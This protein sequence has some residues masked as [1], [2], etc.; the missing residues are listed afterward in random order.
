MKIAI[1]GGKG[2][3][4]GELVKSLKNNR[5][6]VEIIDKNET[7]DYREVLVEQDYTW[8]KNY[9]FIFH[10]GAN[11]ST[12]AKLFEKS[13]EPTLFETNFLFSCQVILAALKYNI[14][15]IFASSGAIYGSD[16]R[17]GYGLPLTDYGRSKLWVERFI[18][19]CPESIKNV[20]SLRF[21]NVYGAYEENK[22][23][24]ASI[25]YKVLKNGKNKIELFKGS[26][27]I[28]R[29]FIHVDDVVNCMIFFLNYYK[30]HKKLPSKKFYDV[31]TGKAVSFLDIAT[32]L[33]K[34][35][36]L[37]IKYINNPYSKEKYQFFTQ[38]NTEDLKKL[39]LSEEKSWKPVNFKAGIK[40]THKLI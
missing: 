10:L 34:Y 36:N 21:H 28:K 1:T 31:G 12:R 39:Y 37:P 32:E 30:K 4:G 20:I 33:Q 22:R 5:H 23:N 7:L 16:R 40:K 29:D 27:N 24:M 18:K 13:K 26:E 3:I 2:F 35:T 8:V 25:V 14:P 6:E 17:E 38:A 9:D 11:S 19:S 15:V